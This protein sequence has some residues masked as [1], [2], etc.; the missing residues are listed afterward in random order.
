MNLKLPKLTMAIVHPC[1][2]HVISA[3][4][5]AAEAGLIE[6]IFVGPEKD[7]RA[8]VKAAKLSI[9]S[10]RLEVTLDASASA[11]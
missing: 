2:D 9:A 8:A 1:D 5:E 10:F 3:A 4:V 11:M 6:P 7:I